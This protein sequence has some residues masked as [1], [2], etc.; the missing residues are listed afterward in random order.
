MR[1]YTGAFMFHLV[2]AYNARK[3]SIPEHP[4]PAE[5]GGYIVMLDPAFDSVLADAGGMQI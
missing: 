1:N 4:V 3:L 5:I 2:E